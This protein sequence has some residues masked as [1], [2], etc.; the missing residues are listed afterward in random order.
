MCLLGNS[1]A[2][3]WGVL[4]A[5]FVHSSFWT[6]Y[7]PN[8]V[9]LL[10]F[11]FLFVLSNGWLPESEWRLRQRV[12][13]GVSFP[14]AVAANAAWLWF[15][16]NSLTYGASG[17]DF[18][19]AGVTTGFCLLNGLPKGKTWADLAK[20]YSPA[21]PHLR[22]VLSNLILFAGLF[23]AVVLTPDAF[24]GVG[25]GVN[26]FAHGVSFLVGIS[27]VLVGYPF[28]HELPGPASECRE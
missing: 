22:P 18:A 8:M 13:I 7:L 28:H 12:L 23:A 4:T 25:P 2:S 21:Q 1:L 17:F 19:V 9:Y 15:V 26:A 11:A 3:P 16:P 5:I 10:I 20:Y 6:H 14:A 27:C 24:L